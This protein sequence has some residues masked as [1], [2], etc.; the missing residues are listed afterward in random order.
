MGIVSS[1]NKRNVAILVKSKNKQFIILNGKKE[2]EYDW[3]DYDYGLVFSS[4]S[5]KFL[6][7]NDKKEKEYDF[8]GD[9]KFSSDGNK[10]IYIAQEKNKYFV[11]LNGKES[12]RHNYPISAGEVIFSPDGR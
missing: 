4:D 10:V 2:K 12:R 1:P 3:I 11:V 5:K 6:V 9:L 7:F 8:V